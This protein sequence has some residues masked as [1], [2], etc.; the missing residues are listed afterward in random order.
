MSSSERAQ[1]EHLGKESAMP[2]TLSADEF[3]NA[4]VSYLRLH[5]YESLPINEELDRAFAS[6]FRALKE[7]SVG[8]QLRLPFRIFPHPTYGDS[9]LLRELIDAASKNN[10]VDVSNPSF[11][12]MKPKLSENEADHFLDSLPFP[13]QILEDIAREAFRDF[14]SERLRQNAASGI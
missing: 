5:R 10:V 4:L 9:E 12:R 11:K 8:L 2:H 3:F 1:Q 7:K 13:R 14:Q 6:A